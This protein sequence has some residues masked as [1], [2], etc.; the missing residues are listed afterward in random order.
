[1]STPNTPNNSKGKKKADDNIKSDNKSNSGDS[2]SSGSTTPRATPRAN[3]PSTPGVSPFPPFD[4]ARG[5]FSGPAPRPMPPID[6]SID[7]P[8][9][10]FGSSNNKP[11]VSAAPISLDGIFAELQRRFT[12]LTRQQEQISSQTSNALLLGRAANAA[13]K[14]A[15]EA[16]EMNKWELE[17]SQKRKEASD[18]VWKAAVQVEKDNEKEKERL[19]GWEAELKEREADLQRREAQLERRENIL[20]RF[21]GG[22]LAAE[23]TAVGRTNIIQQT[24]LPMSSEGDMSSSSNL[25]PQHS[26]TLFAS[27]IDNPL[28]GRTLSSPHILEHQLLSTTPT[29]LPYRSRANRFSPIRPRPVIPRRGSSADLSIATPTPVRARASEDMRRM[30]A[31]RLPGDISDDSGEEE[32]GDGESYAGEEAVEMVA[33]AVAVRPRERSVRRVSRNENLRR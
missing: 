16:A 19:E 4:P 17:K 2:N 24:H 13:Q 28:R 8:S 30:A 10:G 18:A 15:D 14:K 6:H 1:M 12:E 33:E 29:D 3:P 5:P 32:E 7:L 9:M 25:L 26:S 11:A 20:Q 31:W 27:T 23:L 21:T 22:N